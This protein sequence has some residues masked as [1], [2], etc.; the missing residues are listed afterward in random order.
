MVFNIFKARPSGTG[1]KKEVGKLWK[2][3]FLWPY[4]VKISDTIPINGASIVLRGF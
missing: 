1:Q 3:K 2:F 4:I